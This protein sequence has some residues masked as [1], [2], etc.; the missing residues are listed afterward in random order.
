MSGACVTRIVLLVVTL[1]AAMLSVLFGPRLNGCTGTAMLSAALIYGAALV[2]HQRRRRPG[3]GWR[4]KTGMR[5]EEEAERAF[6]AAGKEQ[7][8]T[9]S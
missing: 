9:S 6:G 8:W 7:R 4:E 1:H 2:L 5:S 3:R